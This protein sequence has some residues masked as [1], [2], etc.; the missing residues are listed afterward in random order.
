MTSIPNTITPNSINVFFEG[1][2]R[3]IPKG[4][5]NFQKVETLL[6]DIAK[7]EATSVAAFSGFSGMFF[8]SKKQRIEKAIS[9]LRILLDIPAYLTKLTEGLVRVTDKGVLF[10]DQPIHNV[11]SER[12]MDH[13]N[14]GLDIKPLAKFM[15]KVMSNPKADISNELFQWMEGAKLPIT[16][17]GNFLAFKKVANDYTSIHRGPHGP[18]SNS[19]GTIVRMPRENVDENR[20]QTCS[21]GLHFCGFDYLGNYGFGGENKVVVVEI[22]PTNVCAI[23]TDYD[24]QKG[25]ACEYLV[26]GEVPHEEAE[27]FFHGTPLVTG[28]LVSNGGFAT[29]E[30]TTTYDIDDGWYN[31]DDDVDYSDYDASLFDTQEAPA[32]T[33]YEAQERMDKAWAYRQEQR[34][35]RDEQDYGINAEAINGHDSSNDDDGPYDDV[36]HDAKGHECTSWDLPH[37]STHDSSDDDDGW[38]FTGHGDNPDE[39]SEDEREQRGAILES[40]YVA[41]AVS[42]EQNVLRGREIE[43]L[44]AAQEHLKRLSA[45]QTAD[46]EEAIRAN[47]EYIDRLVR[48]YENGPD[49]DDTKD[50]GW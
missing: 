50:I 39:M 45:N 5:M 47:Q 31:D 40:K 10:G 37:P 43:D 24:Y 36:C 9:K 33:P 14:R 3:T 23:P 38:G 11:L 32:E 13:M 29:P 17:E 46:N 8:G 25:R 41:D 19:I 22:D 2:M 4:A 26:V 18:V 48:E 27:E 28:G 21:S 1:R 7:M 16:S 44:E 6:G 42:R 34:R 49:P 30:H 12:I 20:E 15:N 35:L